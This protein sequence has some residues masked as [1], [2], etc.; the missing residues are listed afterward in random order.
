MAQIDQSVFLEIC[1]IIL[2]SE[3]EKRERRAEHVSI[4]CV[5]KLMYLSLFGSILRVA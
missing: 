5:V 1:G 2:F 3:V 4:R